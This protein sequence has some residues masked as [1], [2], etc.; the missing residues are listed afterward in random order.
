MRRKHAG[1]IEYVFSENTSNNDY[2]R[3]H[4]RICRS[5]SNDLSIGEVVTPGGGNAA[6]Q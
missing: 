2:E 6:R 3:R 1:D 5:R 4:A